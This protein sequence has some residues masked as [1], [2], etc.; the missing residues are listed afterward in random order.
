MTIEIQEKHDPDQI[1]ALPNVQTLQAGR[2]A[3][4]L[5]RL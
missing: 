5:P 3:P 4:L 1:D 2:T